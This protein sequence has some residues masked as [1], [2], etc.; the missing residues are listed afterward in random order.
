MKNY[1][2]EN[3][4]QMYHETA[5]LEHFCSEIFGCSSEVFKIRNY[6]IM[7]SD[8]SLYGKSSF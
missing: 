7:R 4:K 8:A 3:N 1:T 5:K 6:V 2:F